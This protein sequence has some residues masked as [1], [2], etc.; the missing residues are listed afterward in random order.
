MKCDFCESAATVFLTQLINDSIKKV[1][2]CD[3]CAEQKGVTDPTGYSLAEMLHSGLAHPATAIVGSNSARVTSRKSCSVCGFTVDDLNRIRRFGCCECYHAFRD[4]VELIVR[5]MH[6]GLQ[7]QGKVPADF[8]DWREREERLAELRE[9]LK[10]AVADE[11]YET[12]AMIRDQIF[13]LE[14]RPS[15]T[16]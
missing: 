4:E 6:H 7:H 3:V 10:D 16:P 15:D 13:D 11:N 5:G 14:P 12:A 8:Q 2:L 1:C 9:Q